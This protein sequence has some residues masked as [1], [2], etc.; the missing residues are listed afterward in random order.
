MASSFIMMRTIRKRS[1]TFVAG[2]LFA[3]ANIRGDW[4]IVCAFTETVNTCCEIIFSGWSR[5]PRTAK[6]LLFKIWNND[7]SKALPE[8]ND[9]SGV[10]GESLPVTLKLPYHKRL[11][12]ANLRMYKVHK[13]PTYKTVSTNAIVVSWRRK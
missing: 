5:I 12:I 3:L 6:P 9:H 1:D 4:K 7:V 2:D 10:L 13:I 11:A 8:Q